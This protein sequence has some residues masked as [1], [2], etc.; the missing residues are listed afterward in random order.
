MTEFNYKK[1]SISK[2]REWVFDALSS[3]DA[4]AQEIYDG[5]LEE[6]ADSVHYHKNQYEK[7]QELQNLM[8]G[9]RQQASFDEVG[10]VW[11][12][13]VEEDIITGE[14]W[15]TFPPELI[16]QLGW[17]DGDNLEWVD[18]FNGTFTIRKV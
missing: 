7:C 18:N 14:Q 12:S 17:K 11:E 10:S 2:L 13:K 9:H 8:L 4:S 15:I 5:I 16:Q 1:Y 3:G 6:V